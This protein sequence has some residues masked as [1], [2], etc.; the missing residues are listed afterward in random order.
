MALLGVDPEAIRADGQRWR[1]AA[2][3]TAAAAAD[4][5]AVALVDGFL[6][7]EA[8]TWTDRFR[9]DTADL[10]GHLATARDIV[11]CSLVRYA[12][13]LELRRL[14]MDR[15]EMEQTELRRP[16]TPG[17]PRDSAPP[18]LLVVAARASAARRRHNEAQRC[19]AEQQILGNVASTAGISA[20]SGCGAWAD[21]VVAT[22]EN[23][24]WPRVISPNRWSADR[25]F[26]TSAVVGPI[27]SSCID[28]TAG[29]RW[30]AD[31]TEEWTSATIEL[32]STKIF[33]DSARERGRCSTGRQLDLAH[34]RC[35]RCRHLP[36]R[37]CR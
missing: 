16:T 3:S 12:E 33:S 23:L 13:V 8:D 30:V 31:R 19:L 1:V 36:T 28:I 10:L 14:E 25:D 24:W 34:V 11:G 6:G 37:S 35:C 7:T 15:L 32:P 4:V 26:P 9:V 27:V 17:G 21:S 20:E 2:R 22:R 29:N 18:G 5:G